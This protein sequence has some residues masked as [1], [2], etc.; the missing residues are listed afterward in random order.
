MGTP[1][2]IGADDQRIRMRMAPHEQIKHRKLLAGTCTGHI[3]LDEMQGRRTRQAGRIETLHGRI[4]DQGRVEPGIAR[5][6]RIRGARILVVDALDAEQA[7]LAGVVGIDRE[8][9]RQHQAR[10]KHRNA[11][12]GFQPTTPI[13]RGFR[14]RD[15]L[16]TGSR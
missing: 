9:E 12:K 5:A 2:R 16:R 4:S 14:D 1:V 6:A 15:S 8:Q 13:R 3:E 10:A 7:E 11:K